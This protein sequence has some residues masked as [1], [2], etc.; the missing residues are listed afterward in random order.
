VA[1]R[2]KHTAINSRLTLLLSM[3]YG[4]GTSLLDLL[5]GCPLSMLRGDSSEPHLLN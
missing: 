2:K 3:A 4:L 1:K 5:L